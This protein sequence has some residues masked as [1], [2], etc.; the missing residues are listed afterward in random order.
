M[1]FQSNTTCLKLNK[2]QAN[3]IP[4]ELRH[5]HCSFGNTV[6]KELVH[7]AAVSE[8]FLTDV[9][10]LEKDKFYTGAHLPRTHSYYNDT[11]WRALT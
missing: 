11:P 7:R 5:T 6:S 3:V 2:I 1:E 9:D 8:V 10:T 4:K